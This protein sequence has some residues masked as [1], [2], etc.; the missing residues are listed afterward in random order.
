[1]AKIRI[2]EVARQFDVS[3]EAM[4]NLLHEMGMPVKNHMSSIDEETVERVRAKFD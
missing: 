3:S 1:M 4:V 2:Y